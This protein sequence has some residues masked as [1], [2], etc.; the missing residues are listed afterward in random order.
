MT[1]SLPMCLFIW[2]RFVLNQSEAQDLGQ[3]KK[4]RANLGQ[5]KRKRANLGQMKSKRAEIPKFLT[6]D[7]NSTSQ[8]KSDVLKSNSFQMIMIHAFSARFAADL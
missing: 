2:P 8:L 3:M 6:F 7:S 1:K 5:M 4:K